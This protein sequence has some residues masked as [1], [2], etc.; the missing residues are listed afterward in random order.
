M[1]LYAKLIELHP[2]LA[3]ADFNPVTGVIHLQDD[4]D[5]QGPY[6]A[7]WDHPTIARPKDSDLG[8]TR[9]QVIEGEVIAEAPA[10]EAPAA[11]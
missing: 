7:R 4:S 11:E 9:F 10:L 5:G 2:E 8:I 1:S 3:D 6:I